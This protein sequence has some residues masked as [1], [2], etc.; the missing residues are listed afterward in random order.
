MCSEW[1]VLSAVWTGSPAGLLNA[2]QHQ[3]LNINER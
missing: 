3:D 2:A 1:S